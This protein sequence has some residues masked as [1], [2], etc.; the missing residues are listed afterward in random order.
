MRCFETKCLLCP[1]SHCIYTTK[2]YDKTFKV[3]VFMRRML[4]S[5][6][7]EHSYLP[8][9]NKK[10]L[11]LNF[12][13]ASSNNVILDEHI[14][15]M[16]F[17]PIK[18]STVYLDMRTFY[19]SRSVC[20]DGNYTATVIVQWQRWDK[21]RKNLILYWLE[22]FYSTA[23]LNVAVNVWVNVRSRTNITENLFWT[24]NN[25]STINRIMEKEFI[26]EL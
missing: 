4:I 1:L 19:F 22:K 5:I 21:N 3:I 20:E 10:C 25:W 14:T 8:K 23:R 11:P 9:V 12:E 2:A 24:Q 13:F 17:K 6:S 16:F 18:I 26:I 15:Q 7:G